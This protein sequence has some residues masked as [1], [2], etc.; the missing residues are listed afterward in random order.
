MMKKTLIILTLLPTMCLG[1][2]MQI[3]SSIN[4]EAAG[5]G[6]GRSVSINSNGTVI[7][8]GANYNQGSGPSATSAGGHVRVYE[9]V[10]GN[11]AQIGS[12]IDG[13]GGD[14]TGQYVSL[15]QDGSTV[16][17][18]EPISAV[19]GSLS[20]QVRVFRKVNNNWTQM[21]N[22]INGDSFNW[23]TGSVSLSSDGSIL[24]VGSRGAD[25]SG[26]GP[27]SGKARIYTFQSGN[28]V[29]IGNDINASGQADYFGVSI[30][31]SSDGSIVAVGAIGDISVNEIG[32]ISVFQNI[33]GT[34]TQ[35]GSNINGTTPAGEFGNSVGLSADGSTVATG[36]YLSLPGG[37]AK[38]FKNVNGIWTQIGNTILGNAGDFL[39]YSV[40]LSA[41]GNVLGV[42]AYGSDVNGVDAGRTIVF[43]NQSGNWIQIGNVI[44]GAS[45][46]DFSGIAVSLSSDGSIVATGATGD[47][48]NGN[49]AGHVRVF[50]NSAALNVDDISFYNNCYVFPN[51]T[52]SSLTIKCESDIIAYELFS[53]FGQ[54]I[55][56][57]KANGNKEIKIK[58]DG[59]P[60]GNYLVKVKT[61]NKT[62]YTKI[63]KE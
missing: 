27:F 63:V 9:N 42:G 53:I 26:L 50:E 58:L 44:N 38:V 34:W 36:E 16:A 55:S 29:Q 6:S 5:D 52:S 17:V 13:D 20:G 40:S 32:Y 54:L 11:W 18:G 57:G 51:P 47:D 62:Y 25:V 39:G 43:E 37:S 4:G 19:N 1:Q 28:W 15:S 35:I 8:I 3:G 46:G 41:N 49:N 7:A 59:L 31:L 45:A 22:S 10:N 33:A 23:Q 24:A 56:S 60:S 12:D 14:Q 2:W 48:V 21:G 61:T 30:S